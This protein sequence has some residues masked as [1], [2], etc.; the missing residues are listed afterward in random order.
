LQK[1]YTD[2][3]KQF[4]LLENDT[5]AKELRK[6]FDAL[7]RV[8][9]ISLESDS[10]TPAL[11]ATLSWLKQVGCEELPTSESCSRVLS[12]DPRLISLDFNR[13]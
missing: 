2:N 11:D 7:K 9:K 12:L 4:N 1:V 5:V 10:V 3:P 8:V 6:C 13:L